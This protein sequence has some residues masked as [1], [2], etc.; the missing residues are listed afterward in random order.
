MSKATE[1][2]LGDLH[3]A[4]AKVLTSQVLH[5]TEETTFDEEGNEVPTGNVAFD[6]SPATIA[7]A[8]K[9]LKDNQITADMETDENMNNL[10]EA[11]ARKQKHSRL[12]D[13]KAAALKVV[14]D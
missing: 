5:E 4:V 14:G 11:L 12:G 7:A 13:A 6:A 9:F 2:A 8:I 1:L 3:G 10:R